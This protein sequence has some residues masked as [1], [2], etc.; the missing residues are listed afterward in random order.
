MSICKY[1]QNLR[2]PPPRPR[3]DPFSISLV[4]LQIYSA[5]HLFI[6]QDTQRAYTQIQCC[7]VQ[8]ASLVT[9]GVLSQPKKCSQ[10]FRRNITTFLQAFGFW[11][12]FS[13]EMFQRKENFTSVLM[14][15]LTASSPPKDRKGYGCTTL[16]T[17]QIWH[18][19]ANSWWRQ[20]ISPAPC[21]KFSL[22]WQGK[23]GC[24]SPLP[25]VN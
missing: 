21:S 11:G 13:L 8:T 4:T 20:L 14:A 17:C 25:S 3:S 19:T 24:T 6:L 7:C 12:F 15:S 5:H 2:L 10:V 1:V 23:A 16:A 18:A 22:Y 9:G